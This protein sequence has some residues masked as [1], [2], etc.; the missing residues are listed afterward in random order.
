MEIFSFQWKYR[1][2]IHLHTSYK[3]CHHTLRLWGTTNIGSLQKHGFPLGDLWQ[4][5][6]TG[7]RILTNEKIDRQLAGWSSSTPLMNI[8]EEHNKR[9]T[10]DT[11][12]GLEQKIDKLL[13]M[14]GRLVTKMK[15]R[16]DSSNCESIKPIEVEDRKDATVIEMDSEEML[17][18]KAMREIEVGHMVGKLQVTTEGTIKVAVTVDQGQVLEQVPIEIGLDV[19]SVRTMIIMQKTAQQHK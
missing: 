2:N 12:D 1:G 8:W 15:N 19:S 17:E 5:V 6:E 11:M 10:F 18:N 7:K 13:V 16:T 3:T 14:M 9:V 4:A